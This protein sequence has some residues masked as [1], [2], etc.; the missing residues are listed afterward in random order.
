VTM[1]PS[2]GNSRRLVTAQSP[3]HQGHFPQV[4]G[5]LWRTA[6]GS[7]NPHRRYLC[8]RPGGGQDR[9]RQKGKQMTS[10]KEL[11]DA[12]DKMAATAMKVKRDRDALLEACRTAWYVLDDVYDVDEPA[13]GQRKE[14]PFAGA[15]QLI[16]K[17]RKAIDQAE[18]D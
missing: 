9:V 2:Y 3:F 16:A 18:A 17:L 4:A 13:P 7:L 5:A 14:Y 15:G 1:A 10:E 12:F 6:N 8:H 11:Q